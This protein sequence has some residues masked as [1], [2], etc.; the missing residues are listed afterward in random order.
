MAGVDAV[1]EQ[2]GRTTSLYMHYPGAATGTCKELVQTR[3]LAHHNGLNETI[4]LITGSVDYTS[5]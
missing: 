5:K 1:E 4:K 3:F 2:G